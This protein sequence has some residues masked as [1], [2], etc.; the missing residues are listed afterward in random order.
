MN[1]LICTTLVTLVL[2][3]VSFT[4]ARDDQSERQRISED[5]TR[6][7]PLK[8]VPVPMAQ[9]KQNAD[10]LGLYAKLVGGVWDSKA[11]WEGGKTSLHARVS[12]HWMTGGTVIHCISN[13]VDK[14]GQEKLA[15]DS[16]MF[17]HPQE[18][19]VKFL[20]F[21]TGGNLFEGTST[22]NGDE[23]EHRWMSHE[24]GGTVEYKETITLTDPNT[25]QWVVYR[26]NG[27]DWQKIMDSIYKREM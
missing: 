26:K 15:Y 2:L 12:Y 20:S 14:S 10:K 5:P 4:W 9:A 22:F 21:G 24:A 18:K 3:C 27:Q 23:M 8:H 11:G 25:Y 1:R 13:V 17:W 6:S 19:Q 7:E 16:I